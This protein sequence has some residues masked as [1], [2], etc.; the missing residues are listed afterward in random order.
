MKLNKFKCITI[1]ITASTI[2]SFMGCSNIKTKQVNNKSESIV[3]ETLDAIPPNI[4]DNIAPDAE[5]K[6]KAQAKDF[7]VENLENEEV[8]LS[9]YLGKPIVIN[10]W[11]S[12]SELCKEELSYFMNAKKKYG[13]NIEFLMI[14]LIDGEKETIE[15]AK[16]FLIDNNINISPLFDNHFEARIA[17]NVTELPRTIFIDKNGYVQKS[18]KGMMTEDY[19]E[20]LIERIQ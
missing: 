8:Y 7:H 9:Q 12:W 19:L 20:E 13:E 2:I 4:I 3:P 6:I 18:V 5:Q 1:T 16:Q 17:Y 15:S 11:A 10:F 14:N